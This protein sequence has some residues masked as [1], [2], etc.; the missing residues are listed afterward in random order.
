MVLLPFRWDTRARGEDVREAPPGRTIS[1]NFNELA[2]ARALRYAPAMKRVLTWSILVAAALGASDAEARLL[3][4]RE[5]N[6]L[7]NDAA[8][9]IVT[10]DFETIRTMLTAQGFPEAEVARTSQQI[11][12]RLVRDVRGYTK[13]LEGYAFE[14][15][16]DAARLV[17]ERRT[18]L[19][20]SALNSPA[21]Y[22]QG[23]PLGYVVTQAEGERMTRG[24][25]ATWIER[26]PLLRRT[27]DEMV[28][29]KQL[30]DYDVPAVRAHVKDL[31]VAHGRS[32]IARMRG[33]AFFSAADADYFLECAVVAEIEEARAKLANPV[34]RSLFLDL[35][36]AQFGA[37]GD[38]AGHHVSR[39]P[40]PVFPSTAADTAREERTASLDERRAEREPGDAPA[41]EP[42]GI[43]FNR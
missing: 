30:T 27:L 33:A 16:E 3:H 14:D 29:M 32:T 19:R 25:M 23:R 11:V 39:A 42:T 7:A 40:A 38:A 20:F 10:T 26:E 6:E 35:A 41:I 24:L 1:R 4:Q 22:A 13:S 36:N 12:Q 31:A 5:T 43:D 34:E 15:F 28:M 2:L 17:A 8:H 37:R 9:R 21:A 18:M